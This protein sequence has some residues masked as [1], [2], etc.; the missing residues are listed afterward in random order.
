MRLRSI[1]MTAA[2]LLAAGALS[3]STARA[4]Q[5]AAGVRAATAKSFTAANAAPGTLMTGFC[6]GSPWESSLSDV[7]DAAMT[8]MPDFT[9]QYVAVTKAGLLEH[10]LFSGN[11]VWQGWAILSQPGVTVTDASIAGMPDGSAQVIEVLS[12]GAVLHNIRYA[13]GRW[14]GWANPGGSH[15]AQIAIAAMPGG[16]AQLVAVTASGAVEH[17]VRYANG[18]WQGWRSPAQPAAPVKSVG[19]AG[20]IDGSAQLIAVTAS[21]VLEHDIRY[22]N[23]SWQGWA[24]P[25]G[26][27]VTQASIVGTAIQRSNGNNGYTTF[28]TAATAGGAFEGNL[29]FVTGSWNGW[30]GVENPPPGPVSA[31]GAD[32]FASHYLAIAAG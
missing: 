8:P 11:L 14:Q 25:G 28:V 22:A 16:S 18:S 13:D 19:I 26:G 2:A 5:P 17:N 10:N 20:V 24:S 9:D 1:A 32:W 6:C 27:T 15:I 30:K 23:G 7:A 3:P 12:T 21:G 31:T 29:R 4:D